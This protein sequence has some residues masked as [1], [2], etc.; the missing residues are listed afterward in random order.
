MH[1]C[2]DISA[3]PYGTGVS[4]YTANLARAL[5]RII[6]SPDLFSLYGGSLRQ[7]YELSK[8]A[9]G[10]KSKSKFL[11][12][13]PPRAASFLYNEVNFSIDALIGNVDVFHSW[14][15]Y[16]PLSKKAAVVTT[17][18][19][20]AL[21]KFP[22]TA[23]PDIK[24]HHQQ[25]MEQIKTR[26]THVIAVSEA[27]KKDLIE[28]FDINP[29]H[30]HIIYEALPEESKITPTAE[31][32][33]AVTSKYTITKPYFLMVGTQE[34]R[35]N[36]PRQINAWRKFKTDFNLVIVGKPAWEEIKPEA[37]LIQIGYAEGKELASLYQGAQSLLYCSLA[38]GFGLPMLEA[39]YHSLPVV[40]SDV[41]SLSE[42]ANGATIKVDPQ[43]EVA[44]ATGIQASLDQKTQLV[45]KGTQRLQDFSWEKAAVETLEVYK[46]AR[47]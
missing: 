39:F 43:D 12:P 3:V 44:I 24:N 42:I 19:D 17:V 10:I 28:L 15:W 47:Q 11:Y 38:E 40:T 27:T 32:V 30:I 23:H 46:K 18:H 35:K 37:G 36:Y 5:S 7:F 14:D 20:V 8:S 1:Y 21:F 22:D 25:V 16:L 45:E 4:R 13:L 34:P 29:D 41:S 6:L 31:D 2:L 33:L 26:N 9:G